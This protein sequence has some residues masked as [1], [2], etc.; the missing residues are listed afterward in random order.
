MW[1]FAAECR[2]ILFVSDAIALPSLLFITAPHLELGPPQKSPRLLVPLLST[3]STFS[4]Q[5]WLPHQQQSPP[6]SLAGKT[7]CFSPCVPQWNISLNFHTNALQLTH[8]L[9]SNDAFAK[10]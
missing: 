1:L 8:I 10:S 3:I 2:L 9:A 7:H 5:I 4:H 6:R